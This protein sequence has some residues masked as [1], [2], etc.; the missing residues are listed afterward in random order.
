VKDN[1][2]KLTKSVTPGYAALKKTIDATSR[3]GSRRV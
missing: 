3:G 2:R 1:D